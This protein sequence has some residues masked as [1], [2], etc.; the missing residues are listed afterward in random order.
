M[1][2]VVTFFMCWAPFHVQRLVAVYMR[3]GDTPEEEERF[4]HIF[5]AIT[6]VSGVLYFMSTMINPIL[7]HSMSNKF[8]EAFWV[9]SR[10]TRTTKIFFFFYGPTTRP[11][12]FDMLTRALRSNYA[13]D[14]IYRDLN[15]FRCLPIPENWRRK[16][17]SRYNLQRGQDAT[18]DVTRRN[19]AVVN[20]SSVCR[21]RRNSDAFEV[22]HTP[23]ARGSP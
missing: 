7:Y 16:Q 14:T 11:A 3:P 18:R 6:Y 9:R 5:N 15:G 23:R 22:R 12:R 1:A 10:T 8:R 17:E 13:Q 19:G 20:E 4:K 21:R 2:V